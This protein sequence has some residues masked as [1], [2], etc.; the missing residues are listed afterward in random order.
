MR[1]LDAMLYPPVAAVDPDNGIVFDLTI[2]DR[3]RR[4]LKLSR[5]RGAMSE[6][7]TNGAWILCHAACHRWA[8][9]W[10]SVDWTMRGLMVA[11]Y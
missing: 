8:V 7:D 4:V 5:Q 6:A 9:G 3:R 10:R 2:E 1:G 11:P